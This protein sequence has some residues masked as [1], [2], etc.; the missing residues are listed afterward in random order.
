MFHHPVKFTSEYSKEKLTSRQLNTDSLLNMQVLIRRYYR[1]LG[2]LTTA[3]N[4]YIYLF[5][6]YLKKYKN[7]IYFE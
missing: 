7:Y 5:C 1:L 3:K 4:I 2:I 6:V